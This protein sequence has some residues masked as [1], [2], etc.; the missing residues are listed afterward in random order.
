MTDNQRLR[1]LLA[2]VRK[3]LD[4]GQNW[5]ADSHWCEQCDGFADH[6]QALR[7]R[8][9][10]ALAEP[11]AQEECR[12]CTNNINIARL[13]T[14]RGNRQN[15]LLYAEEQR[16]IAVEKERDYLKSRLTHAE[17]DAEQAVY[18]IT[19]ERDEALAKNKELESALRWYVE[20]DDTMETEYNE[21]WLEGKRRA[22]KLLG[23]ETDDD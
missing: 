14:S 18:I 12:D 3:E 4:D 21:P 11:P 13:A 16:R 22:M 9:D 20:H 23:M 19:Q 17:A 8:I 7:H 2:D 1:A 15:D 10:A 5:G 6:D